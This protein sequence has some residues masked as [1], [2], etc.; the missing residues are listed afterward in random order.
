MLDD[1]FV[2]VLTRGEGKV[3]FFFLCKLF[4]MILGVEDVD[5]IFDLFG[6]PA[7]CP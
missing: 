7:M 3:G 6:E 5:I 2:D 4:E 1:L